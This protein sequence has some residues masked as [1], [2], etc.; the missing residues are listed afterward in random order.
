LG[1][2]TRLIEYYTSAGFDFLGI[3]K[4]TNTENLAAH[5]Q[6]EPNCCY[7]EIAINN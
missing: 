2:N 7:F 6:R 3:F 1:N 5:Y 4:L